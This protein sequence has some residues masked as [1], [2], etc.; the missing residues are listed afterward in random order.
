[1][2]PLYSVERHQES[3]PYR[4][5]GGCM[6]L[7]ATA[8]FFHVVLGLQLRTRERPGRLQDGM[9]RRRSSRDVASWLASLT[10]RKGK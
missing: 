8:A 3:L 2:K 7:E 5:G 6:A 10:E 4:H 9:R 1:V